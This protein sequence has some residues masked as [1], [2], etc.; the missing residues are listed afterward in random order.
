MKKIYIVDI[1]RHL[2]SRHWYMDR[3]YLYKKDAI[4]RGKQITKK[5]PNGGYNITE[6]KLYE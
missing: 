5:F 6:W 4:Q 3:I 2:G 1:N